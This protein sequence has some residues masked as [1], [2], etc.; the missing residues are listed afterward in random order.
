MW[1]DLDS[2]RKI[3]QLL[4]DLDD[5]DGFTGSHSCR[6]SACAAMLARSLGLDEVAVD[7]SR[8][9][10]LVHDIGKIEMPA[11]LL[12]KRTGWSPEEL[13]QLRL[14]PVIG[15]AMLGEIPGMEEL[16]PIV[17]HHHE[18]WDGTGFPTHKHTVGIPI[19]SRVILVADT[20]DSMTTGRYGPVLRP[21]EAVAEIERR[22]GA[23][24]DPLLVRALRVSCNNGWL[25][26]AEMNK[27]ARALVAG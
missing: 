3:D 24:F 7:R 13:M 1:T 17:L 27:M 19:E 10:G 15:A 22:S 4:S 14:H 2:A 23:R 8:L 20:F 18:Y 6:V 25:H 9:G 21:E 26:D 5:L 16:A 11:S 12:R